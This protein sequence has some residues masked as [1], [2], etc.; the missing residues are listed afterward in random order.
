MAQQSYRHAFEVIPRFVAQVNSSTVGCELGD[1]GVCCWSVE[2]VT[3]MSVCGLREVEKYTTVPPT[4]R[5][6]ALLNLPSD[7][8]PISI[9]EVTGIYL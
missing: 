9:S 4:D 8:S 1:S 3:S 6:S 5:E 7:I 2:R